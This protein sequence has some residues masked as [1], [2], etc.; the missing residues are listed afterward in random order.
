MKLVGIVRLGRDAE[1]RYTPAGLPIC[2]FSGAFNYGRKDEDGQKPSQ[3]VEFALFG[4]RGD[5]VVSYLLKGTAVLVWASDPHVETYEKRDGG[6]GVKLVARVDDFE[7]AGVRQQEDGH[8]AAPAA[9]PTGRPQYPPATSQAVA[10][11]R[12]KAA[13]PKSGTG[14]DDMDDDIPF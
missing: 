10:K 2:N 13:A 14:F 11:A 6:T 12:E 7:F 3:W 9:A 4:D 1:M 5:K 8:A